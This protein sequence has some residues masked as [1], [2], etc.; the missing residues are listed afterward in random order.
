MG[1]K[2]SL[3]SQF[4]WSIDKGLLLLAN[5]EKNFLEG[6]LVATYALSRMLL[7]LV[8]HTGTKVDFVFKKT[9]LVEYQFEKKIALLKI[10]NFK[11]LS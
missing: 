3:A 4:L 6:S 8:K 9:I 2:R 7:V 11:I 10:K 5:K 1:L